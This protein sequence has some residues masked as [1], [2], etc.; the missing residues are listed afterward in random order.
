MDK[1]IESIWWVLRLSLGL[2][3]LLAGVDKFFNVLADW[4]MYISPM[5]LAI[6]P[7]DPATFMHVVGVVE[8][9][10][11]LAILT[12][13]TRV[14]AWVAMAWL[15][16]IAINLVSTGMFLDLAVRDLEMAVSAYVLARLTAMRESDAAAVAA[17]PVA[18]NHVFNEGV[19]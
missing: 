10:V 2:A 3:P 9:A 16:G 4:Q 15:V 5:A 17:R 19:M 11:G 18:R 13:A 6:L 8:I 7:V 14:G 1:R 12:G